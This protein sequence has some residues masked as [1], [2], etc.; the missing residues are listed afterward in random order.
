M[1]VWELNFHHVHENRLRPLNIGIEVRD[2]PREE[3]IHASPF[4]RGDFLGF[5]SSFFIQE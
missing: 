1:E 2:V 4:N 3:E 5:F